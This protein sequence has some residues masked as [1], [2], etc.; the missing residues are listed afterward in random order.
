MGRPSFVPTPQQRAQ[1]EAWVKAEVSIEE[2]ARR[3]EL[4]PKTFRKHFAAELGISPPDRV[5]TELPMPAQRV[6]A[7]RP[8]DAQREMALILAGARWPY[9][10]IALE[11]G[12]SIDVLEE[13]FAKEL[14]DGPVKFPAP[15]IRSMW[16]AAQGG[17]A[18]AAKICLIMNGA[19]TD[20]GA[21]QQPAAEGLKGKKAAA[22]LGAK[23][24]Q[25]GTGWEDLVA[26]PSG[27]PN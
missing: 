23:N 13:H 11:I 17:N 15:V 8:N 27:K 7:F 6:E 9:D 3:L 12:V 21:P 18:T 26:P 20:K 14:R 4:A 5:I 1:V 25:E 2:M 19:G 24:A 16:H 22:A 10:D